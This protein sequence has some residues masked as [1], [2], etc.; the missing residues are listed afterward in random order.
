MYYALTVKYLRNDRVLTNKFYDE[1]VASIVSKGGF[2]WHKTEY[3]L[4]EQTRRLHV[5]CILSHSSR[6]VRYQPFFKKGYNIFFR[7]IYDECWTSYIEKDLKNC[8]Y[9]FEDGV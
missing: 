2:I 4:D 6:N 5:H 3:E 7:K 9:M 8:E 1:E